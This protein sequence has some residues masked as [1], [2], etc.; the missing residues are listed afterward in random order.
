MRKTSFFTTVEQQLV[1]SLSLYWALTET[2]NRRVKA[3]FRGPRLCRD[4]DVLPPIV[5]QVVDEVQKRRD[6]ILQGENNEHV[7]FQN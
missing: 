4:Y 2:E 5:R 3:Y 7:H 1:L 6:K